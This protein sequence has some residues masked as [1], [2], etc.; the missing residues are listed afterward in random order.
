[1]F[2]VFGSE[3]CVNCSILKTYLV[4]KGIDFQYYD[5]STRE[6]LAKLASYGLAGELSIPILTDE[7]GYKLDVNEKKKEFDKLPD[8]V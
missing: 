5:I 2:K 3:T 8:V 1:M 6:G 4:R 7:T